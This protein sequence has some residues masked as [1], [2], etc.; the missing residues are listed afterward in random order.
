MTEPKDG[1]LKTLLY[2]QIFLMAANGIAFWLLVGI[3]ILGVLIC[4]L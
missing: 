3:V 4:C 2:C 1:M